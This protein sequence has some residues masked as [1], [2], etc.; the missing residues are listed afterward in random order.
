MT[1]SGFLRATVV[2]FLVFPFLFLIY[3]FPLSFSGTTDWEELRWAFK[4]SLVQAL[5]S[6]LSSLF[7]GFWVA[8]G[9]VGMAS[10]RRRRLVEAL[11]LLPNFL[12][13]LFTLLAIL[14]ASVYFPMGILG[15]VII[16]SFMNFGLVGVLLAK[17]M[18][19]KAGP[20][21]EVAY[22]QGASRGLLW[23]YI[24]FPLLRRDLAWLGLFVFVICFGSFSVPLI[25]GGGHGTTVEVLIYEKI[26]LSADW[27]E[28]TFLALLQ[29]IFIFLLSLLIYRRDVSS[30][31]REV[32]LHMVSARSGLIF[33]FF[34]MA[35]YF[36]GYGQGVISGLLMSSRF[37]GMGL[38]ILV[39]FAGSLC[40]GMITGVLC[41]VGLLSIAY[42]W[43]RVWFEKFLSGYVAPSTSLACFSFLIV[44]PNEGFYPY[45]KIPLVLTLLS[46]NGLFRLGWDNLLHS[47]ESQICVARAMGASAPQVFREI[48]LPQVIERAGTLAGIGAVWACGD[49]AVSRILAHR[50]ISLAMMTDAL[51]SGYRLDQAS[52]LSLLV[53][54][55]GAICFFI[56]RGGSR[57]LRG[58]LT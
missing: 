57:V 52:V 9:L 28:G 1:T 50:E 3:Q 38:D 40:V 30:K 20:A 21:V 56:F 18:E 25:V 6:S 13:P 4:N 51:M 7:L 49:F 11:C 34:S 47:L 23:R 24:L 19:D 5:F 8:L 26:R 33:L 31:A 39:A 58:K 45:V 36:Y 54:L 15:V 32:F 46:L 29:S 22:V 43:P 37:S 14:G 17:T 53:I 16:H 10:T 48:L 35:F 27:S 41:L 12:P 44:S 42:C 55:S 2:L